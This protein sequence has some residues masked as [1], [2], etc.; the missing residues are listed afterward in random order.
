MLVATDLRAGGRRRDPGRLGPLVRP[1]GAGL[2]APRDRQ[3]PDRAGPALARHDRAR[4]A[5]RPGRRRDRGR[6]TPT[7]SRSPSPRC[8]TACRSRSR[9]RTRSS[10]RTGRSPSRWRSR[11]ASWAPAGVPGARRRGRARCGQVVPA[12]ADARWS[13]SASVGSAVSPSSPGSSRAASAGNVA[14]TGPSD[15][16]R[17]RQRLARVRDGDQQGLTVGQPHHDV[18]GRARGRRRGRPARGTCCAR[19]ARGGVLGR[20]RTIRSGRTITLPGPRPR[21]TDRTQRELAEPAGHRPPGPAPCTSTSRTLAEP[22][23]PAT[24]AV[25]R[26][27][28]D[29]LRRAD[30]LDQAV[31]HHGEPVGHGQR[32]LLVVGDVDERDADRLLERLELEL[33]VLAQL[34]VQ[35]TERLVEQQHRRVEHERAGERD[36]LLLAAGELAGPAL[37]VVGHLHQLERLADPRGAW[38]RSLPTL[39]VAQ[40]ERDV[41]PHVEE[42]EQRV[43]LEDRVDRPLCGGTATRSLPSSRIWPAVGC[44]KPAIIRSVV[45]LPQPD[46]P[47]SEKNSPAAMSRSM[48]RTAWHAVERLGP[49]RPGARPHRRSRRAHR[50][51]RQPFTSA[52]NV[53]TLA[54]NRSA[55]ASVVLHGE[56]PLL[57]LA[58]RRQE[59]AAVVLHQPVQVAEPVV[60]VEEVAVGCAPGRSRKRDAALGADR[61]DVPRQPGARRG[62]PAD[63]VDQ[64]AAQA[65]RRARRPR[66]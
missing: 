61:D 1:V 62:P 9:S 28:V 4:R 12:A 35:R 29:R 65:R 32:L 63:A 13:G 10:T 42:R 31:A 24:Y 15:H 2:P 16:E 55:S 37:G 30:L 17:R 50:P 44:S 36:A 27:G 56:Q 49:A 45:V 52:A 18:R 43:G 19:P 38:S 6:S 40:A 54:T 47:S 59:D 58:P 64:P 60:D 8:S 41:V 21:R 5:R 26:R 34:G 57:D 22:R 23:K 14:R 46:G 53:A 33:Q 51:C 66:A 39:A 48:P 11:L 25:S 3:G 7:T 20:P